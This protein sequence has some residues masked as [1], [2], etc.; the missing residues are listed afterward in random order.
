MKPLRK[1]ISY[2]RNI[3]GMKLNSVTNNAH[4]TSMR[5]NLIIT[6]YEKD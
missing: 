5:L 6:C 2:P 4:E 1:T 3:R